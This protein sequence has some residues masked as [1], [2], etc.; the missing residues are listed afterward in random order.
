LATKLS[1]ALGGVTIVQ[2]GSKDRITNGD[3]TL[4]NEEAGSNRRCGG[5]GDV[6]S[7]TIGAFLAW[8]MRY[9]NDQ[10]L[11]QKISSERIPLLAAYAACAITRNA[12]KLTFEQLGRSMQTSD[13]LNQVGKSFDE[14]FGSDELEPKL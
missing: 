9:E 14:I 7:G 10:N 8:G 3:E 5:Q 6:L 13:V 4:L 11:T 2:K 1:K 12:S